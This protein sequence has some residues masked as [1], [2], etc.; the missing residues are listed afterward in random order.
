M[1]CPVYV[2]VFPVLTDEQGR[3]LWEMCRRP[4][5]VGGLCA[6]HAAE[7]SNGRLQPVRDWKPAPEIWLA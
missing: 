5:R 7:L 6:Q 2:R 1:F 4:S 3:V